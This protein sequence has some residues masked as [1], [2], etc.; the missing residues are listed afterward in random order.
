MDVVRSLPRREFLRRAGLAGLAV[1]AAPVLAACSEQSLEGNDELSFENWTDYID[2]AILTAFRSQSG[3]SVQYATYTSNDQLQ[4]RLLLAD[5]PR[6]H[7]RMTHTFDLMVPSDNFVQRFRD[8][9]LI[10]EVDPGSKLQ[11]IGNLQPAFQ[12][13]GFDPGNRYTIPWATGTT[14]IGYDASILDTPPDWSV[15][16]NE[17][18]KGKMTMLDEIRDAYGAALLSLGKDPN[19]TSATDIDAATRQL[20]AMKAVIRGFDST[21]Y[22]DGL[23]SGDLVAAH[24]YSG[25]VLQA[26]E[27]NPKLA[28]VLP[29]Q[30]ALRWVDSLAVPVHAPQPDNA[31][32]F[33]D[34]YLQPEISAQ[35]SNHIRY[36]TANAAAQ[37]LLDAAI[38]SDPVI[39]PPADVLAK[40]SFT[41]DLGPEVEKLYADGWKQVQGA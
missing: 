40:L 10:E 15:F 29:P 39:F 20:I 21:T 17:T 2:P 11:N 8:L 33:M 31:L 30:G 13:E 24:A 16:L 7:G 22:L 32:T 6:R 9:D 25:D 19:A 14:G 38:R 18:Y 1:A 37:P 5:T 35:V 3:I 4:T 41:D 23:A 34:F 12:H 36:D 28:F 26:K 27:R